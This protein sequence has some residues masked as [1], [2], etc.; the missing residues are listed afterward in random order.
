M[1]T[2]EPARQAVLR[3]NTGRKRPPSRAAKAALV[4]PTGST[5]RPPLSVDR[6]M[7]VVVPHI[8][9]R[10]P[11]ARPR[12]IP[13]AIGSLRVLNPSRAKRPYRRSITRG[14]LRSPC[15]HRLGGRS[16]P[17]TPDHVMETISSRPGKGARRS[18]PSHGPI[19]STKGRVTPLGTPTKPP[20][21][22]CRQR[23]GAGPDQRAIM[24]PEPH[25]QGLE[26]ALSTCTEPELVDRLMDAARP[27]RW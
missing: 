23:V 13:P 4:V 19:P 21:I 1:S 22:G 24:P 9:A 25:S 26:K 11:A 3:C 20:R 15:T 7:C 8:L 14:G 16:A 10:G 2:E 17:K 6:K 5:T 18:C 12:C 27:C